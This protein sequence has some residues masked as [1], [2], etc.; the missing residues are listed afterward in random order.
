MSKEREGSTQR[1]WKID[2]EKSNSFPACEC[3][4]KRTVRVM[5]KQK[6]GENCCQV[7]RSN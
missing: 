7:R 1:E 5:M 6:D 3:E 4:E 2:C